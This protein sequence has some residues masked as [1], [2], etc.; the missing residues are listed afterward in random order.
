MSTGQAGVKDLFI[1]K[2]GLDEIA[3]NTSS[4]EEMRDRSKC[5]LSGQKAVRS[6]LGWGWGG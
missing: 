4:S 5:E 1:V 2:K 3:R 6:I